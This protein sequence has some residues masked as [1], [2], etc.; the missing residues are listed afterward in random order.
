MDKPIFSLVATAKR[1]YWYRDFYDSISAGANVPFEIVFV[2]PNP[3]TQKMPR[4]FKYIQ[5]NV[6]PAQCQEIAARNAAGEYLMIA[7]DDIRYSDGF[8][9]RVYNYTLKLDMQKTLIS[10]RYSLNKE[11]RDFQLVFQLSNP[12]SLVCGQNPLFLKSTWCK[13]GGIDRMFVCSMGDMDMQMRFYEYGMQ[14]FLA[15]DC[16]IDEVVT[17][18]DIRQGTLYR[19]G[20]RSD[21][22]YLDAM[23]INKSSFLKNRS[24]KVLSFDDEDILINSQGKLTSSGKIGNF[25]W[26]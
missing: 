20:G 9:N 15:P 13:L 18:G 17:L 19:K 11:I 14:P 22:H 4:N 8:L 12:Y 23:W 1:S 5:T 6:K 10:F 24:S 26:T 2:G 25:S 21:T 3:P 7:S 16:I